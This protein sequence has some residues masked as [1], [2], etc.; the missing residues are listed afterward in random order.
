VLAL[1]AVSVGFPAMF[2]SLLC[3]KPLVVKI[4][5]DYAWEQGRQRGLRTTLDAFVTERRVPL[6]LRLFRMIQNRVARRAVRVIVPSGYLKG[7]VSAWGIPGKKIVVI[8]NAVALEAAEAVPRAIA[9]LQK[10]K[11]VVSI[12]RLVPWKGFSELID[13]VAMVRARGIAVSLAIVGDGPQ[14]DALEKKA[15]E[16]LKTDFVFAGALSHAQAYAALRAADVFVL[17]SLYE[18]LSHTLVE[19]FMAGVAV[20]ASD[21][22]GNREIVTIEDN[23]LLVAP[24][25]AGALCDALARVLC[26]DALRA[27]LAARAK[28]SSAL[29]SVEAMIEKTAVFLAPLV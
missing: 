22:G 3:R 28:E 1:D 15:Q 7:I 10:N 21:V 20:V 6:R 26:D 17:D 29:F 5:G 14:R 24:E 12:G 4:V 18:G 25:N 27:R 8:H 2:A 13:A 9:P 23:G 19:A 11:L 16:L